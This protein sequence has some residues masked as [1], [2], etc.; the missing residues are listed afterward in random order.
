[1]DDIK[2]RAAEKS[3]VRSA[4][5]EAA[6]KEMKERK[7]ANKAKSGGKVSAPKGGN[8]FQ[9]VPKHMGGR[10]KRGGTQR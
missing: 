6:L 4:A 2:K 9:K 10:G 7:A 1:L 5:R 3:S 8:Q